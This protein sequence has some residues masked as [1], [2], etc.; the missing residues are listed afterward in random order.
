MVANMGL[1]LEAAEHCLVASWGETTTPWTN[2]A[3]EGLSSMLEAALTQGVQSSQ[4]QPHTASL[5]TTH[6]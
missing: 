5:T 4:V 3:G 2:R 6:L 1:C